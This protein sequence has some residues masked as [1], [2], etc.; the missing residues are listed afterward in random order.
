MKKL[1]AF[2][3]LS[4]VLSAPSFAEV[5]PDKAVISKPG[6]TRPSG[7]KRGNKM[8]GMKCDSMP[9]IRQHHGYDMMGGTNANR[10]MGPDLHMLGALNLSE[11]QQSKI[12]KL[13]DELRHNNW[14][15]QGMMND[16]TARLRDLYEADNRDP[17]AIGKEYQKIFDL[18]RQMI[19]TYLTTQNR[20]EEV[21]TPE[22]RAKMKDARHKIYQ[23]YGHPPMQ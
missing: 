4:S 21:L 3:L 20:I 7:Q 22:Q 16:E 1:I 15:T 19:E 12:N 2:A 5:A 18:K 8:T 10:M 13:S 11:E 9:A 6:M 14:A 17:A 23:M